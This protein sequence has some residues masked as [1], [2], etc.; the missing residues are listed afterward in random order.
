M[1]EHIYKVKNALRDGSGF[2][3]FTTFDR[4]FANNLQNS[5]FIIFSQII[6]SK[7]L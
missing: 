7:K 1:H 2:K 3:G 4:I 5:S 6:Y